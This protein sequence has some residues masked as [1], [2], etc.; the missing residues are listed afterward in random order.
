LQ[1]KL[2]AQRHGIKP[3]TGIQSRFLGSL[4]ELMKYG[5]QRCKKYETYLS[6]YDESQDSTIEAN[7]KNGKFAYV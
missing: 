1:I 4:P 3:V 6:V 2:D 7:K 5:K